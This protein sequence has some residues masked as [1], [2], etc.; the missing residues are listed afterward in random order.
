MPWALNCH[1]F[2]EHARALNPASILADS[3]FTISRRPKSTDLSFHCFQ[4]CS[5]SGYD[6]S[7]LVIARVTFFRPLRTSDVPSFVHT[8]KRAST[9]TA[10]YPPSEFAEIVKATNRSSMTRGQ[11]RRPSTSHGDFSL[12]RST[13]RRN[14]SNR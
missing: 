2:F 5:R 7:P 12:G 6:R 11:F 4:F 9:T 14:C 10:L 8:S 1:R 13:T 3:F